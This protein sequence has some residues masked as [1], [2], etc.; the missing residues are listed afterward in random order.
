M[1]QVC[2]IFD[3][4]QVLTHAR[5]EKLHNFC[6][7]N[8]SQ[9][10]SRKLMAKNLLMWF[11]WRSWFPEIKKS[12]TFPGMG[13]KWPLGDE[14]KTPV[15]W[16]RPTH[17]FRFGRIFFSDLPKFCKICRFLTKIFT[18]YLKNVE[19]KSEYFLKKFLQKSQIFLENS[20]FLR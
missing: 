1:G 5:T 8:T 9:V 12:F 11:Q 3:I 18:F 13:H 7:R 20:V 10:S 4:N 2:D 14:K 17:F 15:L 6:F 19:N 16:A